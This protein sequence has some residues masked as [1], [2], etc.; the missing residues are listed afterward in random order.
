[1]SIEK[2]RLLSERKL[3]ELIRERYGLSACGI[4]E[5]IHDCPTAEITTTVNQYGDDREG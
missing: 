5:T 3:I 4:V 1:M 2:D